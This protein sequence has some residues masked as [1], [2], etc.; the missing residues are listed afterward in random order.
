MTIKR[1]IQEQFAWTVQNRSADRLQAEIRRHGVL[2]YGA[3]GYGRQLAATLRHHGYTVQGFIDSHAQPGQIVDDLPVMGTAAID[4]RH[5]AQAVLVMAINNFRTAI[6]DVVAW[7]RAIGFAEILFVPELPD[8]VDPALG[9]YWQTSRALPVQQADSIARVAALLGDEASGTILEQLVAYRITGRPEDHPAVDRDRQYFPAD[10]PIGSDEIVVID[11]GAF[12]GDLLETANKAGV[13]LA[14]W[15]AFEPDRRNFRHMSD[16]VQAHGS[17]LSEVALFPCGVGA[18]TGIMGFAAGNA[19]A[20]RG[21]EAGVQVDVETVPVVRLDDVLTLDRLDMVK[22]DIEGFE[23]G[24]LDGMAGLLGRH[25][26]RIAI[27]VYHKPFDL[28]ELPLKIDAMLPGGRYALR[29]HGHNGYD[30]VLYVDW[31]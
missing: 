24:A 15:Y 5:A 26:P 30:T 17:D 13:H 1:I 4:G 23:A 6:D 7:A 18:Q 14:K 11:C 9:N 10:L 29:Q 21:V 16:F 19:D 31:D 20:S 27:A 2:V 25:R 8:V 28:W 3:G 12:P 22:L